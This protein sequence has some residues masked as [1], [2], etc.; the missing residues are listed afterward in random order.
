MPELPDVERFT[1]EIER[2][3]V[4]C[5]VTDAVVS[6]GRVLDGVSAQAF[7]RALRGNRFETARRHGKHLLVR[8]ARGGWATFHFGMT[9][10]LVFFKKLEDEP[11]YDRLR[12]DLEGGGHLAFVDRRVLGRVGL[13]EDADKF[14]A[15]QGLGPDLLDASLD[16]AAFEARLS[17]RRGM[18]K[19]ALM[20]Q[21]LF[22]GA[23]NIFSDEI[24]YRA[25]IHPQRKLE[26]LS[27]TERKRLF[28]AAKWV[29]SSAVKRRIASEAPVKQPPDDW[30]LAHRKAG[31]RCP[32]G[33]TV[34][35]IKFGGRTSYFCPSRQKRA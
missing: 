6:D 15:D 22:A 32:G 29:L 12:F 24:L 2:H 31:E 1:K 25:A 18:I 34:K 20:D 17:G 9:G 21:T 4:G 14:I 11:D 8:L 19:A 23:G 35:S 16:F 26:A 27:E 5:K 10:A 33:G 3:G 28:R 30:L 13:A 7:R